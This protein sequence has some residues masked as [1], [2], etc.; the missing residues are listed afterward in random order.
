VKRPAVSILVTLSLC[1]FLNDL[2]QTLLPAIYPMLKTGF[3][4]N[5]T[6]IGLITLTTSAT[7]SVLQPVVGY[8]TDRT[9]RPYSLAAG[10][11]ILI[12]A[13]LMLAFAHRFALLLAG[14]A[15]M[16]I[17]S[18]IFHP[19][20]SRIAR[21]ASGGQHGLAQ[22]LFQTGGNLGTS[23]G[24]L[25]A[26]FII[27][28]LGRTSIAWFA[29]VALVALV[30]LWRI[31]Q[32]Y[33]AV[34]AAA[35]RVVKHAEI[36]PLP[37]STVRR[38]I[39]V[40]LVLIF[41]KYVYLA[42]LTSFYMFFLIHKFEVSPQTAQLHLFVFLGAAAAGTFI[43][44]PV[45]DRFG[46]K[47]VIW[48]SILGVLPFTLI[49]PYANLFWTDVLAVFVGLILASAFSAIVVYAQELMPGRVGL[50][51]GLFFGFAFGIAG[52]GAAVLGKLADLTSIDV[53]YRVCA[54]LPA[55]GVF[56]VLLPEERRTR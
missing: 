48:G 51:A 37:A 29:V 1:H 5:Y 46:R 31:G 15:L 17:A 34:R 33:A 13:L 10:K 50:V 45:G 32:W 3:N 9:P 11:S 42:S 28:P 23:I 30:L 4:L 6:Q 7:S 55:L 49:L 27:M 39:A 25:L 20:S 2:L 22:S 43:G 35:P 14:A 56:A 54:F 36:S 41:S 26:A 19:E 18:A 38:A 12:G 44:G 40:L 16:G 24:P 21:V 53:V 52:I 47:Y 8:Y